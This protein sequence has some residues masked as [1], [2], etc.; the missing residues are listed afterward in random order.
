M[1]TMTHP[2]IFPPVEV[3]VEAEKV[4]AYLNAGWLPP[5]EPET[6]RDNEF[7]PDTSTDPGE[8]EI[9]EIYPHEQ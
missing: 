9:K 1:T 4:E 6:D 7:D 5:V 8:V 3:E 2:H